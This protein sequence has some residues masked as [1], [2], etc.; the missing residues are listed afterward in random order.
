M[1]KYDEATQKAIEWAQWN[2]KMSDQTTNDEQ[3]KYGVDVKIGGNFKSYQYPKD[4]DE[5]N[6]MKQDEQP[7]R[8]P[9]LS[10]E[11]ALGMPSRLHVL[12]FYENLITSGK[13][14]VVKT[15]AGDFRE[16]VFKCSGFH[17]IG[18]AIRSVN[19]CPGC[20]AKIVKE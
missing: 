8:E 14:M 13:L 1:S 3:A 18:D 15:V 17:I 4:M 16:H 7:K 2:Q 19:F 10:D 9:M 5:V 12:Y 11:E 6:R 20:G